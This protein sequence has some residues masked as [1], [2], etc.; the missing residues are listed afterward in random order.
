MPVVVWFAELGGRAQAAAADAARR[1][2]NDLGGRKI[3]IWHVLGL[4]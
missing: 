1:A 2:R 4:D 3:V